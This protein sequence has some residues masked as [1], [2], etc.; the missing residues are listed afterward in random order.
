MA[1]PN[2]AE[3]LVAICTVFT[4]ISGMV[5]WHN[6]RTVQQLREWVELTLSN[7]VLQAKRDLTAE[8]NGRYPLKEHVTYRLDAVDQQL[9]QLDTRIGEVGSMIQTL[10]QHKEHSHG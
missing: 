4:T 5:T 1:T 7:A 10:I 6:T 2:P 3:A 9:R 8:L